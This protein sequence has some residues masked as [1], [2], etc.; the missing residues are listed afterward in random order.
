[1]FKAI[2]KYKQLDE[3]LVPWVDLPNAKQRMPHGAS[4]IENANRRRDS[5]SD[6]YLIVTT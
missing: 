5:V 2:G 6:Y 4:F 1:M 3:G